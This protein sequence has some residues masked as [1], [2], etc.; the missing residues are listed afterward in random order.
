MLN[1]GTRN[2]AGGYDATGI[3]YHLMGEGF[4]SIEENLNPT[5]DEVTYVNDRTA[6]KSVTGY[7]PEWSFSGDVIKDSEVVTFLRNKAKTNASGIDA[8]A[9]LV[10]YDVWSVVANEVA[11]VKYECAI[12]MDSAGTMVGGEKLTFSGT[13][14]A[15]GDPIPGTFNTSTSA[16]TA[17]V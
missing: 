4:E 15:K 11:A 12:A 9:E 2:A 10:L 1:I 3:D 7:A 6:T 17:T 16:F 8:E 13:I 14:M 5:T